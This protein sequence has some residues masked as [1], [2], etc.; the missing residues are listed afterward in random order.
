MVYGNVSSR[1]P[2]SPQKIEMQTLMN[3]FI[4]GSFYNRHRRGKITC[5]SV[6]LKRDQD[7]HRLW[8][9]SSIPAIFF[10][11]FVHKEMR[12]DTNDM[13]YRWQCFIAVAA[14]VCW[15]KLADWIFEDEDKY[16]S[17]MINNV[18]RSRGWWLILQKLTLG[19]EGEGIVN[20]KCGCWLCGVTRM[21]RQTMHER[22][23]SGVKSRFRVLWMI[24]WD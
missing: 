6:K 16:I 19:R 2:M 9:V 11:L 21:R 22:V 13:L 20:Q 1:Q 18:G 14:V 3:L 7:H 5:T 17:R 12:W 4:V 24:L 8:Y 15:F 10:L 23:F